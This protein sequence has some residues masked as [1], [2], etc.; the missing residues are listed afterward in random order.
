MIYG[1]VATLYMAAVVGEG[2]MKKRQLKKGQ[3]KDKKDPN[4]SAS[5]YPVRIMKNFTYIHDNFMVRNILH[6]ATAISVV[7]VTGQVVS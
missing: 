1:R 3:T 5:V 4:L 6:G 7:V 2:K